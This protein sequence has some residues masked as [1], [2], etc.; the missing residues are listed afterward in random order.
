MTIA[1][2]KHDTIL[3]GDGRVL[4][5]AGSD[6]RDD[7]GLY[8]SAEAYNPTTATFTAVGHLAHARYKLRYATVVMP[9]GR[10]LTAGGAAVPELFDPATDAFTSFD[11]SLGRAP[12]FATATLLGDGGVLLTGGYSDRGPATDEAWLIQP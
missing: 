5:I 10:V 9:D 4:V 7:L 11:S 12:Y 6:A 8:D 2:H 3:L 1:R